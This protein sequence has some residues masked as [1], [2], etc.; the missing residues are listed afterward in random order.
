MG[1]GVI[2]IPNRRFLAFRC[3][4][5]LKS[6]T[7]GTLQHRCS[8]NLQ[9]AGLRVLAFMRCAGSAR[10]EAEAYSCRWMPETYES[11]HYLA[12][13]GGTVPNPAALN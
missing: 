11:P 7:R 5:S 4:R 13:T 3:E 2:E 12:A 10:G 9:L 8:C 1:F 6:G